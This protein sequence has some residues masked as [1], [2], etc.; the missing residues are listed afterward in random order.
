MSFL[1]SLKILQPSRFSP[2]CTYDYIQYLSKLSNWKVTKFIL[3]QFI[4]ITELVKHKSRISYM[5]IVQWRQFNGVFS[6]VVQPNDLRGVFGVTTKKAGPRHSLLL[7]QLKLKSNYN[8]H[9]PY[10]L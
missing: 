4:R 5:E 2:H 7:D 9:M 3:R 8:I 10:F 1:D 6:L